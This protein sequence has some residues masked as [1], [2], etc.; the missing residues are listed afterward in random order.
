M[1]TKTLKREVKEIYDRVFTVFN[2]S[3]E[4]L[5]VIGGLPVSIRDGV[6]RLIE[7]SRGVKT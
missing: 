5:I 3:S 6:Q 2:D 1:S 4:P 7:I